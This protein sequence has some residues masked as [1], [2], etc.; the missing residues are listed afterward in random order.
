[1]GATI[2]VRR[3]IGNPTPS[4]CPRC[5]G[6]GHSGYRACQNRPPR[7]TICAGDHEAL[8]HQCN[9]AGCTA[10]LGK[11]CS[12]AL[13]KCANCGQDHVATS[14]KCPLVRQARQHA[15]RQARGRHFQHLIPPSQNFGIFVPK[16]TQP[17]APLEREPTRGND[18]S[19]PGSGQ[20]DMDVEWDNVP[21]QEAPQ[22]PESC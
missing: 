9:M 14:A 11:T 22:A 5:C 10:G 4:V 3:P 12:H 2:T 8:S 17:E 6:I 18:Q 13:I 19:P 7:C 16:P 21:T 1:M 15:I 20:G